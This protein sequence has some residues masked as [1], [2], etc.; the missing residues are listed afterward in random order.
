MSV[1]RKRSRS[2]DYS[3]GSRTRKIQRREIG[4]FSKS[5]NSDP[6]SSESES[7]TVPSPSSSQASLSELL[8]FSALTSQS[9][10]HG[11]F[12]ELAEAML[13]K[14]SLSLKHG[15]KQTEFDILEIE[16]YLQKS[17]YHEDPYTHGTEEQR[18]SGRWY[19]I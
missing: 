6:S 12:K 16:F 13:C 18:F 8:D 4:T 19:V 15:G 17:E 10:I 2:I 3:H 11:R 5:S 7:V 9:D 1:I 14:H